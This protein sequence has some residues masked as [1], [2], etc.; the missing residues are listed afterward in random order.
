MVLMN[1]G[2]R[3]RYTDSIIN[4]N[5]GGG[6]KKAGLPRDVAFTQVFNIALKVHGS[7]NILDNGKGQGLI[8]PKVT[9][10]VQSRPISSTLTPNPYWNYPRVGNFAPGPQ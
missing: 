1:A 3:A 5:Q 8:F 7:A 4:Q 9:N 6:D 2:K 10:V